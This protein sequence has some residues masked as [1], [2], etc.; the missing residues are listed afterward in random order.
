MPDLSDGAGEEDLR[1]VG[2]RRRRC[3]RRGALDARTADGS[4]GGIGRTGTCLNGHGLQR[5]KAEDD[6]A[7]EPPRSHPTILPRRPRFSRTAEAGGRPP[8]Q[9]GC[10]GGSNNASSA[11]SGA[12]KICSHS[13][14]CDRPIG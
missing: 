2:G 14:K 11:A 7:R 13:S 1:V 12:S 6:N 10:G 9:A 5:N 8:V 4:A 3:R